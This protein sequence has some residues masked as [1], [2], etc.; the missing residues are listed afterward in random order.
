MTSIDTIVVPDGAEYQAVC[1]GVKKASSKIRVVPIALGTK[2]I[3][4]ILRDRNINLESINRLLIVGLCGSLDANYSFGDVVVYQSCINLDCQEVSLES[5]LTTTVRDKLA[6]DLV[7]GITSDRIISNIEEKL[8]LAQTYSANVVDMEGYDCV[9]QLQA[10][11]ITVAILRVVS[12]DLS[13][14]IPDLSKAFDRDGNL[15]PLAMATAFLKQPI[16]AWRLIRGSLT[17]LKV[18]EE[19]I[20]RLIISF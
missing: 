2:N 5:E 3:T 1:R 10:N 6:V 20:Y 7:V 14:D 11:N 17:G 19:S 18:L 4:A 12:D 13:G 16:A 15:K 9:K 8:Q